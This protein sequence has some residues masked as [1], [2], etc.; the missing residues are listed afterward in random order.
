MQYLKP[1]RG[2]FILGPCGRFSKF[3]SA[4]DFLFLADFLIILFPLTV[5][6]GPG[7]AVF[8]KTIEMRHLRETSGICEVKPYHGFGSKASKTKDSGPC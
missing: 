4:R 3:Q 7:L 6:F 5:G 2:V 1:P 8:S